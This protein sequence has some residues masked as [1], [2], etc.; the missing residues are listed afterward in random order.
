[1]AQSYTRMIKNSKNKKKII[2]NSGVTMPRRQTY[3]RRPAPRRAPVPRRTRR[4]R[5]LAG[6]RPV[7]WAETISRYAGPVGRL[8][9]SVSTIAGLVNS[10][11]KFKDTLDTGSA[12][13][14]SGAYVKYLTDI[15]EGD[16]YTQRNGRVILSKNLDI[17]LRTRGDT[18]A[19]SGTA[20]GWAVIM[21]K[22]ASTGLGVSPWVDVFTSTDPQA[23]ISKV[24]SERFVILKRGLILMTPGEGNYQSRKT[25]INLKGIH[26]KYDGTTA[27][28]HDQNAIFLIAVGDQNLLPPVM[29]LQARYNYHDN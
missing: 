13:P 2:T 16:D 23:P 12:V 29:F 19:T 18:G 15:A 22:Q 3:R 26:I 24:N 5:Q 20:V 28:D 9:Q 1:M 7:T 21:D 17:K 6:Q 25:F 14:L 27:N 4:I 8:A 11:T 10:E